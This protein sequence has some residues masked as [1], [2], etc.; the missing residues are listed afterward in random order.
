MN[1]FDSLTGLYPLAKTLPI[2]LTPIGQTLQN[3]SSAGVIQD[4][5]QL[6]EDY[7]RLKQLADEYHKEFIS[8]TL[9]KLKLK[10]ES[11]GNDDSL[12]DYVSLYESD[13]K[14]NEENRNRFN[15]VRAL[16]RLNI[17][18]AFQT[19]PDFG[20]LDKK[21]FV[22]EILKNRVSGADERVIERFSKFTTYLIRY[23]KNRKIYGSEEKTNIIAFRCIEDNL[24]IFYNNISTY[25]ILK[26]KLSPE[27][28]DSLYKDMEIYLNVNNFDEVFTIEYYNE[29][30]SQQQIEVYNTILGGYNTQDGKVKGL[31]EYI[32]L[33]NQ[34]CGDSKAHLPK[35]KPLKKQILSDRVILSWQDEQYTHSGSMYQDLEA[36]H[37]T[38]IE[39]VKEPLKELL[40]HMEEY[41]TNGIF[42]DNKDALN[43]ISLRVCGD[44]RTLHNAIFV[45]YE[46][47]V[48]PRGRKESI[49][50]Y[51]SR[52][53]KVIKGRE[54]FSVAELNGYIED[55][56]TR[57]ENYF[58]GLGAVDTPTIQRINHFA[59]IQNKWA[60][61]YL[62]LKKNGKNEKT[63]IPKSEEIDTIKGYLDA[64]MGLYHFVT[65]LKGSGYELNRDVLFYDKFE[66]ILG[67]LE[68]IVCLYSR[69]RSFL[70]RKPFST[71][72][73]KLNFGSPML[74]SG[75]SRD[76]ERVNRGV[77]LRKDGRYFLA[78]LE[79]GLGEL[80][81]DEGFV[82]GKDKDAVYEKVYYES[83]GDAAKGLPGRCFASANEDLFR[84]T[85][86]EWRIYN[87]KTY[88]A[89]KDFSLKDLHTL[90][91]YY[92]K[93]VKL[94]PKWN[95]VQFPWKET[96]EYNNIKEFTDSFIAS[97]YV[98]SFAD[99]SESYIDKLV[100]EGKIYLFRMDNRDLSP[101]SKGRKSLNTM[102]FEMLFHPD[103][104][105]NVVYKLC[106]GA[107]IFFRK[108]SIKPGRP[109]HPAGLP[110]DNKRP[111]V[112]CRKPQ[113]TF[114]Y[115]LIKDRRYTLDQF[116]LHMPVSINYSVADSKGM[117]VTAKVRELIRKGM[118]KHII[119]IHR[120]ERNLLYISVID[121]DGKIIEQSSLNV[122]EDVYQGVSHA[123][124]YNELLERRSN[125]RQQARKDWQTIDKIRDIKKGYL[126]QAIS[127]ITDK[128]LKYEAVVVLESMDDRFKNDRQ[129]IE[130]N[131][132]QQFEQQL[133]KKLN[134]LVKKTREPNEPGGVLKGYQLTDKDAATNIF[135][136][137]IIFYV[138]AA[139]T[140][141][142]CPVTGFV[143]LFNLKKDNVDTVKSFFC[144]F[145][146]IRFNKE[147]GLFDFKFDYMNFNKK[148]EN[149]RTQWT[150]STS[151]Q[152]VYWYMEN[153]RHQCRMVDL[154]EEFKYLFTSH[155]VDFTGNLKEAIATVDKRSFYD[156]LVILF[157]LLVQMRNYGM[158]GEVDY[159]ISPVADMNGKHFIS[160][161]NNPSLP[162]DIDANTT[163][164][165]A[166]KGLMMVQAIAMA[167]EGEKP[168]MGITNERWFQFV[169]AE[170]MNE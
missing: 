160:S 7:I 142:V 148:A 72:K 153:G 22:K 107:E 133:V 41:D 104:L 139:Y 75:W 49:E 123:K 140:A 86:E 68:N 44:W 9:E 48:K 15:A 37:Q 164:N 25:K 29:V 98:I 78:I 125:E 6:L 103:N 40:T 39:Y 77:V 95:H 43:N 168:M 27:I 31:N 141:N 122:I 76:N 147:T 94:M 134:F 34:A 5:E 143:N 136:N 69:V 170:Q 38:Y 90:I 4:D 108:A 101:Y 36:F 119:G 53:N 62:L 161:S 79:K 111:E 74:L 46:R 131:V 63:H 169:Q 60:D 61:L 32:H 110:I 58:M 35:L 13:R 138:P 50:K 152:R 70:T 26:E 20:K 102:Y 130:K 106:G 3:I 158:N 100:E 16:L 159:V 42:I 157:N 88:R 47:K 81:P 55:E 97:G 17:A 1:V 115:D 85:A 10:V 167:A 92:K 23:N 56:N 117:K 18:N 132:Y 126:S 135:Q 165:I 73:L 114:A 162:V 2:K 65:P 71:E 59:E 21:D 57:V 150:V 19:M 118:F 84:P 45:D 156:E 83:F 66:H 166:R 51:E 89:G 28:F 120:G 30:L 93:C 87:G 145:D 54:S 128:I 112:A 82:A 127:V 96:H 91:D 80:F 8:E 146:S 163:Y 154:T 124:D 116:M 155:G 33:F 151:G 105:K 113:S 52:V 121:G 12:E 137:G 149:T 67:V 64:V 129:K 14:N 109:T 144:K 11:D 24:P 99:F